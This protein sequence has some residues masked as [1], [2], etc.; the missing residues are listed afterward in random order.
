MLFR[1]HDCTYLT[2]QVCC[3]DQQTLHTLRVFVLSKINRTY[4]IH[5]RVSSHYN[6]FYKRKKEKK[7][8]P[9]LCIRAT[10]F[11]HIKYKKAQNLPY[12]LLCI[13]TK[14]YSTYL[15]QTSITYC[16]YK[17]IEILQ[18][19]QI[20]PNYHNQFTTCPCSRSRAF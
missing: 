5:F 13:P 6:K 11:V 4:G 20:V 18:R 10:Y 14:P 17:N 15:S 8:L 12:L 16:E 2:F 3:H 1:L 19:E 9:S 7:G